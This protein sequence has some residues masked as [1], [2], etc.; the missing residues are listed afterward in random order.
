MCCYLQHLSN[1]RRRKVDLALVYTVFW[2]FGAPK[3]WFWIVFY[4]VWLQSLLIHC[5]NQFK[6]TGWVTVTTRT[7]NFII[8]F[9]ND[10]HQNLDVRSHTH[11][12]VSL[13]PSG[14]SDKERAAG[15]GRRLSIWFSTWYYDEWFLSQKRNFKNRG[16]RRIVCLFMNINVKDVNINLQH[17]NQ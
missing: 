9:R 3:S 5:K 1:L 12:W 4:S 6:V 11:S 15:W 14:D 13:V 2:D 7:S 16:Q 8:D 17:I 10:T